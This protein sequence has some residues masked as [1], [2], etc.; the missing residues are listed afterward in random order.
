[1]RTGGDVSRSRASQRQS[2]PRSAWRTSER[3]SIQRDRA[4]R[5]SS[6][7]PSDRRRI[8][9]ALIVADVSVLFHRIPPGPLCLCGCSA[10]PRPPQ[11]TSVGRL[12]PG[13]RITRTM[14][15][16]STRSSLTS[17]GVLV[18][19]GGWHAHHTHD[20]GGVGVGAKSIRSLPT[21]VVGR[22]AAVGTPSPKKAHAT[23]PS[24]HAK[25][26]LWLKQI[27]SFLQS[28]MNY[29]KGTHESADASSVRHARR[30]AHH[31]NGSGSRSHTDDDTSADD[32]IDHGRHPLS[33]RTSFSSHSSSARST[34]VKP[35]SAAR[36][37][38][39]ATSGNHAPATPHDASKGVKAATHGTK[40]TTTAHAASPT[41]S[42]LRQA[43]TAPVALES[44]AATASPIAAPVAALPTS[45]VPMPIPGFN[46][47]Q[48]I[49]KFGQP[50]PANETA[51]ARKQRG[52]RRRSVDT[53]PPTTRDERRLGET[54]PERERMTSD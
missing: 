25:G 23:P 36:P 8:V 52:K 54:R 35:A 21:V 26:T 42:S 38:A 27:G 39:E 16:S 31:T 18:S 46:G 40:H 13:A 22:R 17:S 47:N 3:G 7:A 53:T 14:S 15:H 24:H 48:W 20:V 50:K 43:S 29:L 12:L 44:H 6:S 9:L 32:T 51:V 5:C 10:S 49:D 2:V 34:P 11:W 19:G 37:L 33:H 45:S 1:M 28:P 30:A 4:C 41:L